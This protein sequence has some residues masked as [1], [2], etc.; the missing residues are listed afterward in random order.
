MII[1]VVLTSEADGAGL[2]WRAINKSGSSIHDIANVTERGCALNQVLK[3]NSTADWACGTDNT[4]S[5]ISDIVSAPAT[6]AKLIQDNSTSSS[7]VSLKTLTQGTGITITNNTS[8]VVITSSIT[9]GFTTI[10][11]GLATSNNA[12]LIVENSTNNRAVIKTLSAG[13]GITLINNTNSVL[14]NVTS[15]VIMLTDGN[16]T[17]V[18]IASYLTIFDIPLTAGTGNFISAYLIADSDL[19]STGVQIIANVTGA[20]N[21]GNCFYVTPNAATT[22]ELDLLD[23][24]AGADTGNAAVLN[25]NPFPITVNC[26]VYATNAGNLKLSFQPDATN[27]RVTIMPGSYYVHTP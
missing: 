19:P 13:S 26:A 5:G 9:Q 27:L 2:V 20:N 18:T 4:G 1:S 7:K 6:T 11:S 24:V 12:T 8:D 3:V 15:P 25:P 16:L 10:A 23:A 14:I 22:Q 21:W 17:S